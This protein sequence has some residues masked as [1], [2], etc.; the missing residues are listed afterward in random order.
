MTITVRPAGVSEQYSGVGITGVGLTFDAANY[1][2]LMEEG[3]FLLLVVRFGETYVTASGFTTIDGTPTGWT[4]VA[5]DSRTA[6]IDGT[7][8]QRITLAV[9][10]MTAASETGP[11]FDIDWTGTNP[12][13]GYYSADI[14]AHGGNNIEVDAA[15]SG[16]VTQVP[17]TPTSP[18]P[19]ATITSQQPSLAAA[20][21]TT[22]SNSA[23]TRAVPEGF[24]Q[25]DIAGG[26]VT[27]SYNYKQVPEQ[28]VIFP[29]M[30][31]PNANFWVTANMLLIEPPNLT[32]VPPS[33]VFDDTVTGDAV[34]ETISIT[35]NGAA[36][37]VF[38][39]PYADVPA[40]FTHAPELNQNVYSGR[41]APGATVEVL[42]GVPVVPAGLTEGDY[43]LPYQG[44]PGLL[45]VEM[46]V[47]GVD[48]VLEDTGTAPVIITQGN[49]PASWS[50]E[51]TEPSNITAGDPWTCTIIITTGEANTSADVLVTVE[52]PQGYGVAALR[53]RGIDFGGTPGSWVSVP[54]APDAL[55][56]EDSPNVNTY[57]LTRFVPPNPDSWDGWEKWELELSGTSVSPL[58][59]TWEVSVANTGGA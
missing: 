2:G 26:N 1:P 17:T 46:D 33:V 31:M 32:A 20:F 37:A 40:G 34:Y 53:M 54:D 16:P 41:I 36:D 45:T 56:D 4:P 11:S 8:S 10:S 44:S 29:S 39:N 6:T 27:A 25:H 24:T 23:P 49:P 19:Q 35:N 59:G 50:C 12:S 9:F 13:S 57:Y 47:T 18:T 15:P 28:L 14:Y 43:T 52:W 38:A 5:S 48:P 58:S 21:A 51:I 22:Y 30:A 7:N 3:D 42:L 55:L